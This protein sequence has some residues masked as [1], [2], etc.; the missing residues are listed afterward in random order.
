[1]GEED[2]VAGMGRTVSC[3]CCE[4]QLMISFRCATCLGQDMGAHMFSP[5]CFRSGQRRDWF[6]GGQEGDD[7]VPDCISG[8]TVIL[9]DGEG[10]GEAD[11]W[12]YLAGWGT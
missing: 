11:G 8:T 2:L 10:D 9:G 6:R 12:S 3:D 7:V 1:M 4:S 5:R